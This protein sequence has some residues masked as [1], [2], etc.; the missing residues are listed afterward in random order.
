MADKNQ[1]VNLRIRATDYSKKTTDK[2]VDSLKELVKAQDAQIKSAEEGTAAAKDLAKG[3]DEI[4]AAAKALLGQRALIEFFEKQNAALAD[5]EKRL[6]AARA[7]QAKFANTLDSAKKATKEQREEMTRL[8]TAVRNAQRQHD[9]IQ[10]SVA[11]TAEKLKEMGVGAGQAA[12][13]QAKINAAVLEANIALE[14]QENAI[15][16]LAG[17][18]AQRQR[19]LEDE[20]QAER[21]RT[22]DIIF[23]NAQRVQAER[24]VAAQQARSAQATLDEAKAAERAHQQHVQDLN[25]RI[26]LAQ[27]IAAETAAR[28]A[29]TRAMLAA[30]DAAERAARASAGAARGGAVSAAP[31][32]LA[33]Q[34]QDIQQP[35]AAALRSVSGLEASIASL[36]RRV[37]E[38]NGPVR[39]Y[40]N[41]LREATAAQQA[42][43]NMATLIDNFRNQTAAVRAARA[44]YAAARDNVNG[45]VAALRSGTAGDDITQ[46]IAAGQNALRAAATNL[47][48]LTVQ[49]RASQAALRDA[50]VNTA[51]LAQAEQQLVGQAQRATEAMNGLTAAYQRNG[52]AVERSTGALGG[53]FSGGRNTLSMAQRLRGEVLSLTSSFLGL[54]A[55]IQGAQ[56]TIEAYNKRQALQSRLLVAAGG[57]AKKAGDEY[58]YIAAQADRFGFV[59]NE[60]GGAYAKFAIAAREAGFNT[61]QT[62][63]TFEGVA[64]AANAA[65]LSTGD[66]EGVLKALEQ[67]LSKGT[68][69][70]E[71]L[72]GQ[73]GDRLPGA[74]VIAA[75]AAGKS[76]EEF[77]KMMELGQVPA[78]QVIGIAREMAKTYGVIDTSA[79]T[80]LQAQ[81]RFQNAS[82]RFKNA[83]ADAGAAKAYADFLQ[84]LTE[85]ISGT[86]GGALAVK[87]A[88]GFKALLDVVLLLINN[89]DTIVF[90]FKM[91]V[92]LKLISWAFDAAKAIGALRVAF[93]LLNA[94]LY[95]M[96]GTAVVRFLA[97]IGIGAAAAAGPVGIFTASINLLRVAFLGLARAIP[98]VGAAILAYEGIKFIY[99]KTFGTDEEA[100]KKGEEKGQQ[101]GKGFMKGI[102][103]ATADP[104]N[105]D[106]SGR[107]LVALQDKLFDIETDQA[108]RMRELRKGAA[109]DSLA[110]LKRIGRE[111][112]DA[113]LKQY[114]NTIK[115]KQLL[116]IAKLQI[117]DRYRQSDL[118]AETEYNQRLQKEGEEAAK[119]RIELANTVADAISKARTDLAAKLARADDTIPYAEREDIAAQRARNSFK[120]LESNIE[121]LRR[122]APAL[123]NE[124]KAQLPFL[125]DQAEEVARRVSKTQELARLEQV[126]SNLISARTAKEAEIAALVQ[127]S[128]IDEEEGAR[129]RNELY[130]ELQP[131]IQA[132]GND[133][134]R[135]AESIKEL[136]DPAKYQEAVAKLRATMAQNEKAV[137]VANNDLQAAE[138]KLNNLLQQR[139]NQLRVINAAQEAGFLS[140][141]QADEERRKVFEEYKGEI[142]LQAQSIID[143]IDQIQSTSKVASQELENLKAKMREV[144]ITTQGNKAAIS[145]LDKTIQDSI[146]NNGVKAFED[147]AKAMGE[148]VTKQVSIK[149]GFKGMLASATQFFASVLRDIAAYIAKQEILLALQN[150]TSGNM[151]QATGGGGK[152]SASI[153]TSTLASFLGGNKGAKN[154]GQI[155]SKIPT[156]GGFLDTIGAFLFDLFGGSGGSFMAFHKGGLIQPGGSNMRRSVP[157]S[158]FANAPRFHNGG[159][160]G[161][162]PD[163]IP[164]IAQ[165]GEEMITADDPRHRDNGGVV[166]A[167]QKGKGAGVRVVLVD[168]RSQVPQAMSSAEGEQVIV[169]AIRRNLPTI[170]PMLR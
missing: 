96:T 142:A 3:Y 98:Y 43:S 46:R 57:D 24:D 111:E 73:M 165:Q 21:Q 27:Q 118:I 58:A 133:A 14:R 59:L 17:A 39:D 40:R 84:K 61:Q 35:A 135:F 37:S 157:A 162:A 18:Q 81:A 156:E 163:E 134:I 2:V 90:L 132:A 48:N 109:K 117:G 9:A 97:S 65:K 36:Q 55:A 130:N 158:A 79:T 160:P 75:R 103:E 80:L 23:S 77:S 53:W 82:D 159:L 30:A 122:I 124:L 126:M 100:A 105:I 52:A 41:T 120:E 15:N 125:Q 49:A 102:G 50:G 153:L 76:V 104:G 167:A 119:K 91:I 28:Q 137:M 139:E 62:R 71:E 88:E 63:F 86:E 148:I 19:L 150:E 44:E 6:D 106:P 94:E 26:K 32:D 166:D 51:Q 113:Q 83:I 87:L 107:A 161:L 147:M 29:Q 152:A 85:M 108:K 149:D 47:G 168:D 129:R 69:Q 169:E 22:A 70:A 25:T 95:A 128:A 131:K 114:E 42:L 145:Q 136:L 164:I 4:E 92:G 74:F 54:F 155:F 110:D 68:I 10:K 140:Q 144:Q 1:D 115:D 31:A 34:I 67:M 11:G 13:A 60:V 154:I 5:S 112:I 78:T 89:L 8:A 45:L 56:S 93:V 143:L 170:K 66:F 38:I 121:K 127:Q 101:A 16:G 146:V 12:A 99:D 116:E 33:G 64:K 141:Q 72:R 20:A 151:T 138:K 123:G 7:A